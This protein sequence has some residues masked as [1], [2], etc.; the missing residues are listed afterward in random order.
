[1][2]HF[3]PARMT[4]QWHITHACNLRCQHCYQASYTG[5]KNNFAELRQTADRIL[6]FHQRLAPAPL[7]ITLTGGEPFAHPNFI[8]LLDYLVDR[9]EPPNLA[10][11]TN[12]TLLNERRI[13]ALRRVNPTFVQLSVDGGQSTHDAIRGEGNFDR[14]LAASRQ[15]KAQ[16]V[17]VLWSF[18]AHRRNAQE[19]AEVEK[20]AQRI[21]IDRLWVDRMI[22]CKQS[23]PDA[24]GIAET[25]ALFADMQRI[26]RQRE[27]PTFIRR[28]VQR[29]H[30]PPKTEVAM[31][32]ALQFLWSAGEPYRC[33]AGERLLTIMPDG[34]VLPCRRMPVSVGNLYQSDL[35]DIYQNSPFLQQLRAFRH[36]SA[37]SQCLF[38]NQCRGGL[39]CLAW[40]QT[41]N[42]F[43]ADPGCPLVN[44]GKGSG[45]V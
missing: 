41:G 11:L 22:P 33:L 42:P 14:V 43:S 32:R 15:L 9:P 35:D 2:I 36:P 18:T 34:E 23:Q 45:S 31:K 4:V 30:S 27:Q 8:E 5:A 16:G 6:S 29:L 21:G 24:L 26:K 28:I 3:Q 19:F 25:Q 44:R 10:V 17:R 40:A 7:L 20:A 13:A 37:C 1:M 12:G 39:R 38:K